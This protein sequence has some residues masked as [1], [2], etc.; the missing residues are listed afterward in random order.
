MRNIPYASLLAGGLFGLALSGPAL[1]TNGYFPNGYTAESKGMAGA[2]V[3]TGDGPVASAENPALGVKMG[4]IGGGCLALLGVYRDDTNSGTAGP[5]A[6]PLVPGKAVSD[7]DHYGLPCGGANYTLDD[8]TAAGALVYVAGGLNSHYGTNVFSHFGPVAPAP[9]GIDF[10]QVFVSLN[11]ARR[12]TD[13]VTLGVAPILAGQR[14]AAYGLQPME[15]FSSNPHYVSDNGYDYSFGGGVKVGGLWEPD[16][17]VTLGVSFQSPMWMQK[18]GKYKGLFADGGNFDIPPAVTSGITVRP[19]DRLDLTVEHQAI[20]FSSVS[21]LG[22]SGNINP[23]LPGSPAAWRLGAAGGAGLGWQDIN[24]F[25]LAAQW[26]VDDKLTLRGGFS[27]ATDFI[28]NDQMLFNIVSPA[29]VKDHL[30]GGLTYR[31]SPA[32]SGTVGYT[33]AF[34]QNFTGPLVG[35]PGQTIKFRLEEDELVLGLAYRW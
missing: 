33:H 11:L 21:T 4:N 17:R 31:W 34:S 30:S 5:A 6:A 29:T 23:F 8:R 7:R 14:L 1:A 18:L 10:A 32:W 13:S 15:G 22:N 12:V 28:R 19:V 25:R 35:D 2:G 24:V 9:L 16:P 27:H 3:T 26:R 20:F